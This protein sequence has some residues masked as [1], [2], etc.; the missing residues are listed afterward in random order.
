MRLFA[1]NQTLQQTAAAIPGFSV[2]TVTQRA[3]AMLSRPVQRIL[4]APKP[5]AAAKACWQTETFV[6]QPHRNQS[7]P[8]TLPATP[9]REARYRFWQRGG[10]YDQ[11][12]HE[13]ATLHRMMEYVQTNPARRGLVGEATAWSWSSVRF[14]AGMN[15]AALEMDASAEFVG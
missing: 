9:N 14:Y 12:I 5:S 8:T 6:N 2:F 3:G 10:G 15:D 4:P 7:K 1:A 13:P 11:N